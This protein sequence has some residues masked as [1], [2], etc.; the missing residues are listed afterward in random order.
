MA[1]SEDSLLATDRSERLKVPVAAGACRTITVAFLTRGKCR[2][3]KRPEMT[4][5]PWLWR[6]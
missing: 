4:G 5:L 6:L 2:P 1:T 3:C